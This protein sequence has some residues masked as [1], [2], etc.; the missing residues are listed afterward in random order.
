VAYCH[1]LQKGFLM[2][3]RHCLR[4][5]AAL[6]IPLLPLPLA[7]A[8]CGGDEPAATSSNIASNPAQLAGLEACGS[9]QG[10]VSGKNVP[11]TKSPGQLTAS[12]QGARHLCNE[13]KEQSWQ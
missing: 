2:S 11:K 13:T 9:P 4:G 3:T 12:Q 8:R 1:L 10:A 7:L 6:P 5:G